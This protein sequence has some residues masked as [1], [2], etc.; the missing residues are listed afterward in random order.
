MRKPTEIKSKLG[1]IRNSFADKKTIVEDVFDRYARDIESFNQNYGKKLDEYLSKRKKKKESKKD[2]FSE[3][4]DIVENFISIDD[5]FRTNDKFAIRQKLKN[6]ARQSLEITLLTTKETIQENVKK[7]F[8]AGEGI[9]GAN[10]TIPDNN[11]VIKPKELD[12]LNMFTIDPSSNMGQIVYEPSAPDIGKQKVNRKLYES[13]NSGQYN[14]LKND[15]S[16]LF[17]STW[18]VANQEFQISGL[19][20]SAIVEVNDFFNDYF[21]SIE[22]PDLTGITKTAMML[23]IQGDGSEPLQFKVGLNNLDRLLTK[24]FS[25][26]G[27]KKNRDELKNQNPID[28]FDENEEVIEDYFDFDNIDDVDFETEDALFRNVL[29]FV[30]CDNFE[31]P[32]NPEIIEDFVFLANKRTLEDLVDETLEK[33]ANDAVEQSN[34]SISKQTFNISLINKFI[35]NLPKALVMNVL[36]PKLFL[37][38]VVIYKLFKAAANQ[39]IDVKDLMKKLSK[40]FYGIIKDLFWKFV[41]TFWS[42]IK[43]EL[44]LFVRFIVSQILKNKYK[45]YVN[46]LTSIFESIKDIKIGSIDNCQNLF[47][48]ILKTIEK[49]LAAKGGFNLSGFLLSNSDLVP[50]LN[51]QKLLLGAVEFLESNNISTQDIYGQK[52]NIL[53]L[54]ESV[55]DSFLTNIDKSSYVKGGNKTTIIPTQTGPIVIPQGIITF[56]GK[57]F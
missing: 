41:R 19:K 7:I 16:T 49:A 53:T 2:I 50:E 44:L 13:F 46:I 21:S 17:T 52:N 11:I 23:T 5:S 34:E 15:G 55:F 28:S 6:Y 33:T 10:A 8:F 3:L 26:C 1:A 57:L 24:L 43:S 9:C 56:A 42:F 20:Q 32:I 40:L 37:P 30:D 22:M 51:R 36:S 48:S 35:L 12:F 47:D 25:V 4:I 29:K 38:I 14:F 39:I 31:I 54:V 45:R 18:N 27:S